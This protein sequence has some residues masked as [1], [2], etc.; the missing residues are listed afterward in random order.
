MVFLKEKKNSEVFTSENEVL[1]S[2]NSN[3]GNSAEEFYDKEN[4]GSEI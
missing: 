2:D 3:T 4:T 1:G